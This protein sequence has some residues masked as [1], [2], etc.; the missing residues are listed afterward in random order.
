M[1][2]AWVTDPE[3]YEAIFDAIAA[4]VTEARTTIEAG[5]PAGLGK[6]FNKNQDLLAKLSVSSPA[7]EHLIEA[8]NRIGAL[9]AKL[10]GGG[11][12]G[13]IIAL[14]EPEQAGTIG[15]ALLAAGAKNVIVTRLKPDH[16]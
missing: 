12:G 10:S 8:A 7:L 16:R 1:R 5:D 4:V 3:T 2:S 14:I 11:R 13:N 15:D 9:G 6:L